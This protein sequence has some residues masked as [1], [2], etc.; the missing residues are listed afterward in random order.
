MEFLRLFTVIICSSGLVHSFCSNDRPQH[1][2]SIVPVV[3]GLEV[4]GTITYSGTD[5]NDS[6]V[7]TIPSVSNKEFLLALQITRINMQRPD[8]ACYGEIQIGEL[9]PPLCK[10][11]E[12]TRCHVYGKAGN[13]RCQNTTPDSMNCPGFRSHKSGIPPQGG[14]LS[15]LRKNVVTVST[16]STLEIETSVTSITEERAAEDS[17]SST[18]GVS[19]KSTANTSV[20][21]LIS[22]LSNKGKSHF[23]IHKVLSQL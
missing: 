11:D 21:V 10:D 18:P 13:A 19:L 1:K 15:F 7:W 5:L 22:T 20:S 23:L 8:E 4:R 17:Y 6:C 9:N 12:P 3:G 16:T 2:Q 14:S